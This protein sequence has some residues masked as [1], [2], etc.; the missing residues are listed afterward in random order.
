VFNDIDP[1]P[2]GT[3]WNYCTGGSTDN[4]NAGIRYA[5]SAF[6]RRDYDARLK[7]KVRL[8]TSTANHQ[9]LFGFTVNDLIEP[10]QAPILDTH[11]AFLIG[12]RHTDTKVN[13][14]RN[15][16][17]NAT[18][19]TPTFTSLDGTGGTTNVDKSTG[20]R[21]YEIAFRNQGAE[22]LVTIQNISSTSPYTVSTIYTNTFTT[23]LPSIT[24]TGT[25]GS[26]YMRPV[27]QITNREF[28]N[29]QLELF[30]MEL[31]SSY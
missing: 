15:A 2:A 16:G 10:A 19:T 20:Y 29:H 27:V 22:A 9:F 8:P 13:I 6:I 25:G 26:I 24:S 18:P 28:V 23:N 30:F 7:C 5:T 3:H 21:T 14:M 11:S 1:P 12:Y 17:T 4:T 31:E